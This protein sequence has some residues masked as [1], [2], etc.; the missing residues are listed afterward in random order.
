M[1]DLWGR[2]VGRML[3]G[4]VG[5]KTRGKCMGPIEKCTVAEEKALANA[6]RDAVSFP[7][8]EM[9]SPRGFPIGCF[10][11][12]VK[13]LHGNLPPDP[14]PKWKGTG[15]SGEW[16]PRV[17]IDFVTSSNS[18]WLRGRLRYPYLD[19]S[20][21][22]FRSTPRPRKSARCMGNVRAIGRKT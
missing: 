16:V 14:V 15:R 11:S 3:F 21:L 2:Y 1:E 7:W 9:P 18:D 20:R 13:G 5:K 10:S 19:S 22:G 8:T 6:S 17:R 12:C 4:N